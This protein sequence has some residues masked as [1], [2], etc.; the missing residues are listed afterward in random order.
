LRLCRKGIGDGFSKKGNIGVEPAGSSEGTLP[1]GTT[2]DALFAGRLTVLQPAKGHR[3]GTDAVLLAASVPPE[4]RR[5]ADLGAASGAVGCGAALYNPDAHATLIER[6]PALVALARDTIALNRM[7]ARVIT[8]EADAFRL[9][10]EPDL[11]EA[12]DC[13]LSNPPFFEARTVRASPTAGRASAHVL[14]GTLDDWVKN[15]VTILAPKGELG[16]IHRA[17][18]LEALLAA[19]SRRLGAIRLRCVHPDTGSPA[20]RVL[21]FG[22]KGSRAPL[23]IVP[24]LVLHGADGRFLEAAAAIHAGEARLDMKTGGKSARPFL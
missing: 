17:D 3:A 23:T 4:A 11:R 21:I 10:S 1:P 9:G 2:R 22:R 6:E 20:I 12:F 18:A 15:A 5:I 13:V 24:P 19:F 8:R 7:A 16:M 14:E